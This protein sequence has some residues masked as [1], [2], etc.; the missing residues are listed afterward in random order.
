MKPKSVDTLN[1]VLIFVCLYFA[2][3][4]PFEMFFFMYAFLGPLHY[5]TEMN[6]LQEKKFFVQ[7][8]NLNWVWLLLVFALFVSLKPTLKFLGLGT[9]WFQFK[10]NG[11]VVL[12]FFLFAASIVVFK[13]TLYI[14]LSFVIGSIL[15]LVL[16]NLFPKDGSMVLATLFPTTIHV[17]LFTGLFMLYGAMKSKSK[18]G[19]W[20]VAALLAAPVIIYLI[21]IDPNEYRPSE[22]MIPLI[23][24]ANFSQS[25]YRTAYILGLAEEG[26]AGYNPLLVYALKLKIFFAFA[27]TYHYLN[28]FSKTSVIGWA[29][30]INKNRAYI[31]GGIW[32]VGISI[33]FYDFNMGFLALFF[34]SYLH[35]AL[36]FPLNFI[37]IKEIFRTARANA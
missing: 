12:S 7:K 20:S 15:S 9:E 6:W 28:W 27:Y 35:V 32:L 31:I 23:E 30:S 26:G 29:K 14:L 2:F 10:Y 24:G 1:I 33:Y 5:L 21:P 8:K 16:Y 25:L 11:Y 34:L 19:Y 22:R 4:V 36:E 17:F 37:T 18:L 3:K 13:R